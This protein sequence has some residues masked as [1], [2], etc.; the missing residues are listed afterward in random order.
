MAHGSSGRSEAQPQS[1]TV[2][3]LRDT[4]HDVS[5]E[6]R[7]HGPERNAEVDTMVLELQHVPRF[8]HCP[9]CRARLLPDSN[10]LPH[11]LAIFGRRLHLQVD[12]RHALELEAPVLGKQIQ[13]DEAARRRQQLQHPRV[14]LGYLDGV[15]D[16]LPTTD[17]GDVLLHGLHCTRTGRL[18]HS[19]DAHLGADTRPR[20]PILPAL[21]HVTQSLGASKLDDNRTRR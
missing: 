9:S 4:R 3:R 16:H 18:S 6:S 20:V 11:L 12:P 21:S 19:D 7:D 13:C 5:L 17:I 15:D 1:L 10:V 8:E 14:L 2:H